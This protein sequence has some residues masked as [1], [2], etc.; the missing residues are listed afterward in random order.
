[1]WWDWC[2]V[3]GPLFLACASMFLLPTQTCCY[4][5]THQCAGIRA[6]R[7]WLN[8][9]TGGSS[10]FASGCMMKCVLNADMCV[11]PEPLRSS[12]H[13]QRRLVKIYHKTPFTDTNAM[14]WSHNLRLIT[15]SSTIRRN[16]RMEPNVSL[17]ESYLI[18]SASK[19]N[20]SLSP[21]RPSLRP[22]TPSLMRTQA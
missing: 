12:F 21:N 22:P 5:V 20:S 4:S 3:F 18:A 13:V 19:K 2:P 1:M 15:E 8:M 6:A 9:L 14:I 10:R 7:R 11:L 17:K 16:L